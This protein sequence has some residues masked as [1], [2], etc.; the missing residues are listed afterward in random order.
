M[1]K[2]KKMAFGG[3]SSRGPA[4]PPAAPM[5]PQAAP[6][7]GLN[8]QASLAKP[9]PLAADLA[10]ARAA[11]FRSGANLNPQTGL[12]AGPLQRAAQ[13][14]A[15][16]KSPGQISEYAKRI[17]ES[18]P[19]VAGPAI[20]AAP[21]AGPLQRAAL[22]EAATTAQQKLMA[23]QKFNPVSAG[24]LDAALGDVSAGTLFKKLAAAKPM[25]GPQTGMPGASI[26]MDKNAG[27]YINGR[28]N[29]AYIDP[30][31]KMLGMKKGGKVKAKAA[32]TKKYAK[33][34]SVSSASKRADG[35]A[36]KG[37][38]KGRFI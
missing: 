37:K 31:M 11:A 12:A 33:G 17:Q 32:P 38:T 34:G 16:A 26:T 8:P 24:K 10:A 23:Q 2:V 4:T 30:S 25:S 5:R 7:R 21:S 27:P 29:E 15:I 18:A 13:P 14:G 36:T 19:R 1:K 20:G 9:D 6:L 3:M 28:F 35:I 22:G